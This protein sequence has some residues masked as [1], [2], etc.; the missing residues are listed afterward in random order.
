MRKKKSQEE[1]HSFPPGKVESPVTP[2]GQLGSVA[3]DKS[4]LKDVWDR[5]LQTVCRLGGK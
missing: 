5:A 4:I 2:W 1:L 3:L